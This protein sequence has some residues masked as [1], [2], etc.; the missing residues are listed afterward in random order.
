MVVEKPKLEKVGIGDIASDVGCSTILIFPPVGVAIALYYYFNISNLY[1]SLPLGVVIGALPLI[2][3]NYIFVYIHNRS[4]MKKYREAKEKEEKEELRRAKAA[5][6]AALSAR[7]REIEYYE[8]TIVEN[9]LEAL[10]ALQSLPN[11]ISTAKNFA[12]S[13]AVHYKDGAFSPFWSD[14]EQAYSALADYRNAITAIGK[15]VDNHFDCARRIH[16][17]GGDSRPYARFP[18]EFDQETLRK[19]LLEASK[20]LEKMVY[21]AQKQPVFAQ[22]WEQRRTTSAVIAGFANLEIA[23]RDMSGALSGA[24]DYLADEF[25]TSKATL[26]Q[27]ILTETRHSA[28]LLEANRQQVMALKEISNKVSDIRT[29]VYH[30]RWGN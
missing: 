6:D 4:A 1:I 5:E 20:D 30:Q 16:S 10:D 2:L 28:H 9:S 22:I 21:E 27:F 8:R 19:T 7:R 17:A 25:V 18:V 15:A 23:V 12:E 13:A 11:C 24:I 3:F 29:D 26:D 14:I